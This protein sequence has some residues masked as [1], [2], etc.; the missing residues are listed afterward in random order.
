MFKKNHSHLHEN[1]CVRSYIHSY[2]PGKK[3]TQ[4]NRGCL[5]CAPL[6][7]IRFIESAPLGHV[8]EISNLWSHL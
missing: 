8:V 7:R 6:V 4:I 1:P 5:E 3:P 2:L